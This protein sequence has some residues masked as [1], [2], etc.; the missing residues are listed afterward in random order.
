MAPT[1]RHTDLLAATSAFLTGHLPGLAASTTDPDARLP[2]DGSTALWKLA[3]EPDVA[4]VVRVTDLTER[5]LGGHG[6]I[7][8]VPRPGQVR[9]YEDEIQTADGTLIGTTSGRLEVV[10]ERP[11]DGHR[12]AVRTEQVRLFGTIFHFSGLN[13]L[14]AEFA[15]A[16]VSV[17]GFAI[18]G[19]LAGWSAIRS[20]HM[21]PTP[22]VS[23]VQL[24]LA[25]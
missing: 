9:Y 5:V 23:T 18:A 2:A 24:V 22:F 16:Y 3:T 4:G 1:G 8:P 12:F 19:E 17:P 14:T 13:D 20:I 25:R 11:Q 21:T 10:H 15:G 7:T 6:E